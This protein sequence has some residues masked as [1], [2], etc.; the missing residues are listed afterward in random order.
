MTRP[1]RPTTSMEMT[2]HATRRFETDGEGWWVVECECG[3]LGGTFPSADVAADAY[4]D[5]RAEIAR[6]DLIAR[7]DAR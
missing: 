6:A 1:T 4:G 7:L 5:H 2:M 3:W